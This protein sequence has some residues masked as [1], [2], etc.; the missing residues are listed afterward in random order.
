MRV[1]RTRRPS[2]RS[3]RS[4][5]SLGSPLTRY[6]LGRPRVIARL[7]FV[8]ALS[9]C[10]T[11]STRVRQLFITDTDGYP[12]PGVHI[13]LT[14]ASDGSRFDIVT[15]SEGRAALPSLPGGDYQ[16]SAP[17]LVRSTHLQPAKISSTSKDS[18]IHIR[19]NLGTDCPVNVGPA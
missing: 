3:G 9:G 12:I 7:A 6:P 13:V 10:A 2:L 17:E 18:S 15:N 14:S 1:Q 11:T 19:V 8:L 5:C 16:L 4:R